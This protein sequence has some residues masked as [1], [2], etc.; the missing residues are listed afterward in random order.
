MDNEK[1]ILHGPHQCQQEV[2]FDNSESMRVF[3]VPPDVEPSTVTSRISPDNGVLVTE[4]TKQAEDKPNDGEF[5][6]KLNFSGYKPE[7]TKLHLR[8]NLLTIT[9]IQVSERHQS[10]NTYSRFIVLPEDVDPTS[11]TSFLSGEGLLTIKASCDPAMLSR[12]SSDDI[13]ITRETNEDAKVKPTST[14]E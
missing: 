8:A 6:A 13:T 5:E 7:E 10:P 12:N 9:G 14:D 4:G 1:V 3:T 2:G 11:V